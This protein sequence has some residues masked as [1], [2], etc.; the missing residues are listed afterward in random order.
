MNSEQQIYDA[1]K[2]ALSEAPPRTKLA[3]MHLQLIKY[4]DQLKH[5]P[6]E[7]IC[8]GIGVNQSFR[9]VVAK[10]FKIVDRLKAAGLDTHR[11]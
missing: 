11:L 7:K 6:R 5:L 9:T 4:A 2:K 10:M 1:I 3:E 8:D